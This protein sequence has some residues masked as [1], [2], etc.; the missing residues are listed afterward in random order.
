M[1]YLTLILGLVIVVAG[2]VL[3]AA[4]Y[5]LGALGQTLVIGGFLIVGSGSLLIAGRLLR[6][7][8]FPSPEQ[9]ARNEARRDLQSQLREVAS[10][11][12]DEDLGVLLP[13]Q[14]MLDR[15][16]KTAVSIGASQKLAKQMRDALV[17]TFPK[18]DIREPQQE[19]EPP[20]GRV[21]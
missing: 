3:W 4:S 18:R 19:A 10:A 14:E 16:E 15:L 11:E 8:A 6:R 2:S 1:V 9:R 21:G 12:Y 13:S 7:L 20:F 5:L 17:W